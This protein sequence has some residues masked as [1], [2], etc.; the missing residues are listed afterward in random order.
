MIEITTNLL[1]VLAG[2]GVNSLTYIV[3]VVLP[4]LRTHDP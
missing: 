3:L 1:A 4:R 2:H